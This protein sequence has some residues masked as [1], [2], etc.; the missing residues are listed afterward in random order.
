MQ[1]FAPL[2]TILGWTHLLTRRES[3]DAEVAKAVAVIERSAKAQ[4]RL[5]EELLDVSRITSGNL[6][7]DIKPVSVSALLDAVTSSVKPAAD[8][9]SVTL[10][11]TRRRHRRAA[12]RR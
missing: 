2:S 6:Q 1:E 7:L 4:S 10:L 8:A 11:C 9:R 5:I 3:T 12:G